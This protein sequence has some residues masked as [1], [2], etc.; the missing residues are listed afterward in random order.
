[1][2]S[3]AR[4]LLLAVAP[5]CAWADPA[6]DAA[7]RAFAQALAESQ[8]GGGAFSPRMQ[9]LIGW[10][11]SAVRSLSPAE[12][13]SR[14]I[15]AHWA[16]SQQVQPEDATFTG[17]PGQNGRWSDLSFEALATRQSLERE[18][19]SA[20]Q[21][22]NEEELLPEQRLNLALLRYAAEQTVA[23]HAFPAELMP[24][25]QMFGLQTW[26]ASVLNA[27]PLFSAAD[28]ADFLSR[29]KGLPLLFSQMRSLLAK[30]LEAGVTPPQITLQKVPP[31]FLD[32]AP[33]DGRASPLLQSFQ[34][35]PGDLSAT[36]REAFEQ[37]ALALYQAELRP[38]VLAAA[39]YVRDVYLPGAVR[40]TGLSQLPDGKAW[41]AHNAAVMTTTDLSPEQI[42]QIGLDEVERISAE[43]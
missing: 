34:R 32:L 40:A 8:G 39:V 35:L 9:R 10:E 30:G 20:L 1:M 6:G 38:A 21:A 3:I 23:G 26:V 25:N 43:I 33:E 13:L 5:L 24:V 19:L 42:H 29:L 22:I 15:E 2:K 12:R 4:L 31:Q 14:L 28:R 11:G 7:N 27:Q 37:Q 16:W 17:F 41:Y 36:E 18:F